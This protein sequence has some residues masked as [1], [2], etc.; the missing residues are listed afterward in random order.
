M[1]EDMFLSKRVSRVR[2]KQRARERR[3]AH[4]ISDCVRPIAFASSCSDEPASVLHDVSKFLSLFIRDVTNPEVC[5]VFV[6]H[7]FVN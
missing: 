2:V 6:S 1:P 7:F 3:R 4:E 5:E